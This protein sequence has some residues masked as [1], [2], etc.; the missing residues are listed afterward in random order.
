RVDND[1]LGRLVGP[2]RIGYSARTRAT[3]RSVTSIELKPL[4]RR[5]RCRPA[6]LEQNTRGYAQNKPSPVSDCHAGH[7][8][9]DQPADRIEP[10]THASADLARR[11][12]AFDGPPAW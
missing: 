6:I 3:G 12:C 2:F 4:F 9:R 5:K 1:H 8:A 10:D 7:I 11:P